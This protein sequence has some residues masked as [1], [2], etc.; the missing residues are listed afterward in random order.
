V[1]LFSGQNVLGTT[2]ETSFLAITCVSGA[3]QYAPR[4]ALSSFLV[5]N[6]GIG[7][8]WAATAEIFKGYGLKIMSSHRYG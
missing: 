6:A 3:L 2:L 5:W 8:W 1:V 7:P 4:H